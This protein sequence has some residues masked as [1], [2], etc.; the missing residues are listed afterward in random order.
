MDTLKKILYKCLREL[1]CDFHKFDKDKKE[2]IK[3]Q[4]YCYLLEKI[5]NLPINGSFTLYLNGPYNSK[6]A[7]TLYSI[8]NEDLKKYEANYQNKPLS[9]DVANDLKRLNDLFKTESFKLIDLLEL[10]TTYDYLCDNFPSYTDEERTQE[11]KKFKAHFFKQYNEHDIIKTIKN[12]SN[13][14]NRVALAV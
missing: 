4:K 3:F 14:L 5:F 10:Y 13:E 11:L 12:I 9:N 6:L 2:R 7:D 8:V 1:G